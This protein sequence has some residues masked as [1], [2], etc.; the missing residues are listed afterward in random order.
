MKS[1]GHTFLV[2]IISLSAEASDP[3]RVAITFDD[4]PAAGAQHPTISRIDTAK[5]VI[6]VLRKHKVKNV[7]G[8]LNGILAKDMPERLEILKLWKASGFLLGNHTYSHLD[9][10]KVSPTEFIS[11]IEK[12]ESMLIDYAT[13]IEE[14][15]WLRY[16][17][18]QEGETNEKRYA[19]RSY[20]SKRGYKIAPVS[21]DFDDWGW[22][23]PYIRCSTKNDTDSLQE[24]QKS[25]IDH[26]LKRLDFSD[27]LAKKIYGSQKRFGHILLLHLTASTGKYLDRLLTEYENKGVKW[28]SLQEAMTDS[29]NIEDTTF[30]GPVGKTVLLQAAES[31]KLKISDLHQ[32]QTHKEW[33]EDLCK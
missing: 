12:N 33:L 11:D 10:G 26:S 4:L 3:I 20:L 28:I 13:K 25:F 8:F 7:Y 16:P 31:R 27:Q 23:D 30:I 1:F 22:T 24:L 6:A 18:L 19:I 17:F 15:K 9:L 14:L 5:D 29:A 2:L 32:P 21:I